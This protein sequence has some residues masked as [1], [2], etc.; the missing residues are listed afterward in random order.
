DGV[1]AIAKQ[2]EEL[3]APADALKVYRDIV[4]DKVGITFPTMVV[5]GQPD[6]F[7]QQAQQGM[8]SLLTK[9]GKRPGDVIALLSPDEKASASG[10]ALDLMLDLGR[11]SNAP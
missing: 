3:N 2:L 7:K 5:S 11:A 6:Y 1:L 4:N 10:P 9:V 8:Q